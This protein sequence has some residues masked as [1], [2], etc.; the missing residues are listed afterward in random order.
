MEAKAIAAGLLPPS[1]DELDL[2]QT[3]A[4]AVYSSHSTRASKV[5]EDELCAHLAS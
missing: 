3:L 5:V 2:A 4:S 1:M